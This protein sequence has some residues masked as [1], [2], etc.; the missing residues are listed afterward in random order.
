MSRNITKQMQKGAVKT[1]RTTSP[2]SS[3]KWSDGTDKYASA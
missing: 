2:K 1:H 3:Q